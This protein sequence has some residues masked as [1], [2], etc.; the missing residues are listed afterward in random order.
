MWVEGFAILN[1]VVMGG[2][3]DHVLS[4]QTPEGPE[5]ANSEEIW[6][7]RISGRSNN[8]GKRP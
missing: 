7:K 2:L 6:G 4:E 1:R 5:G 3:S 8:K